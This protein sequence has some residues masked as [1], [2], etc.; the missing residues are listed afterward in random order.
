MKMN[1]PVLILG[2]GISGL[3]AAY[4]LSC[5]GRQTVV[6][7]KDTTYGGLCGNFTIDG[8]RF[9]RFVHFSFAKDEQVNRIFMDGAGEVF[10]HVPNAYNLYQGIWIKHPA[11]NNLYPLSQKMKDAVVRDFLSRPTDIDSSQIENYDQWLRLQFGHFFAE[12]F[13]IPYTKKYWMTEAKDLET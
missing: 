2:A 12:H 11:Q 7:E 13:P 1:N 6:L 4:K 8:F 9:D 5:N 10:R 3:G